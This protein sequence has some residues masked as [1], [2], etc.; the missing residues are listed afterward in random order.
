MV[1]LVPDRDPENPFEERALEYDN[2]FDDN[3]DLF[4]EQQELIIP[5]VRTGEGATLDI[6]CGSG[7]FSSALGIFVGIEPS[8]ALVR[9]ADQR[10]VRVIQGC[11]EYIPIRNGSIIQAFLIT[12]IGFTTDPVMILNEVRRC[13]HPHGSLIVVEIDIESEIGRSYKQRHSSSTFL[14]RALLRSCPDI[15]SLLEKSGFFVS[16]IRRSAGLVLIQGRVT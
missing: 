11:G 15:S 16:D 4:S 12:V 9:M 3:H 13:M 10:G 7:R 8:H 5:F 6:G 2:W 1:F 14:S